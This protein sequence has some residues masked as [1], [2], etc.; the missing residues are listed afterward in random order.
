MQITCVHVK[1]I[2]TI[3][4]YFLFA[5]NAYVCN[6]YNKLSTTLKYPLYHVNEPVG[7]QNMKFCV[8]E[9]LN[10]DLGKQYFKGIV[11]VDPTLQNQV[12]EE[13]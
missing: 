8:I 5:S 7:E 3:H 9:T 4:W 12:R 2:L 1:V 6:N 13:G 10:S 11:F